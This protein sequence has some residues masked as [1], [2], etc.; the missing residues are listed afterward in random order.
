[1]D[2]D[3]HPTPTALLARTRDVHA[4]QTAAEAELL[5]L[6]AAWA[7]AHPDLDPAPRTPADHSLGLA[8]PAP[9]ADPDH[10]SLIP[11]MD[12]RAGAGFAAAIGMSTQAGEALIRDA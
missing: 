12:W 9:D 4:I 5:Q 8:R 2:P 7:D 6:A 11:T 10:D 3:P 1:M